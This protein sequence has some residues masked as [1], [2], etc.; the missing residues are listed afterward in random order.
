MK[1]IKDDPELLQKM[2]SG[3]RF[4]FKIKKDNSVCKNCIEKLLNNSKN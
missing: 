4:K 2:I 3:I 1:K